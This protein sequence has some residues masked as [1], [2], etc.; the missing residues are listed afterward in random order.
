[1]ELLLHTTMLSWVIRQQNSCLTSRQC[2]DQNSASLFGGSRQ[3]DSCCT[4]ANSLNVVS[5][6]TALALPHGMRA[7]GSGTPATHCCI[8]LGDW[9]MGLLL[10]SATAWGQCA[11]KGPWDV[12]LLL[13]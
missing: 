4:M 3:L 7:L 5:G 6:G 1:M 13:H 8:A 2:V 9:E 12:K 11:V 10:H